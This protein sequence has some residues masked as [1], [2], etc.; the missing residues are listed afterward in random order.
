LMALSISCKSGDETTSNEGII[1]FYSI[2][3]YCNTIML[4]AY[5]VCD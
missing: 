1:E 5:M 3:I 2:F 4:G